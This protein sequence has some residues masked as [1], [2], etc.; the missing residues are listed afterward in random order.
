MSVFTKK[1]DSFVVNTPSADETFGGIREYV[2]AHVAEWD[3]LDT[4]FDFSAFDMN[5]VPSEEIR[6]FAGQLENYNQYR[7]GRKTALVCPKDLAFGM[8]RLLE[9]TLTGRANAAHPYTPKEPE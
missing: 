6:L 9:V 1:Y 4:L 5:A 2:L 8:R 7:R 3:A